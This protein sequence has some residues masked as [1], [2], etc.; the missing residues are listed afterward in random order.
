[1]NKT[2][3]RAARWDAWKFRRFGPENVQ[4]LLLNA[5]RSGGVA[6]R[7]ILDIG[8][9]VGG[10]HLSLLKDGAAKATGVDVADGMIEKAK[11]LAGERGLLDRTSYVVGDFTVVSAS[12]GDADITLLDK[13]VCCYEDLDKLIKESTS[14]TK[15]IYALSHP[16]ENPIVKFA[17]S[18]QI[19]RAKFTGGEF[20]TYWH[21]WGA[22]KENIRSLGFE[23]TYSASTFF[24]QVLVFKRTTDASTG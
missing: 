14:K 1:M 17:Y 4:R 9:G 20:R 3:S 5:V 8:C 13:V 18:F 16:K 11:T 24:W 6:G 2:F 19:A 23:L 7:S 10:L 15:S 12:I 22:M 21:D